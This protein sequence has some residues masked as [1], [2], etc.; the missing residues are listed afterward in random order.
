MY[1]L[2]RTNSTAGHSHK[3][4]PLSTAS[5]IIDTVTNAIPSR[6]VLRQA[7]PGV[8]AAADLL[9]GQASRDKPVNNTDAKPSP[10]PDN[11]LN[12]KG[13]SPGEGQDTANEIP[14]EQV[15]GLLHSQGI[16]D[17]QGLVSLLPLN[18]MCKYQACRAAGAFVLVLDMGGV[19]QILCN[20][21]FI[22]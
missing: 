22:V 9:L 4:E 11:Y 14:W 3:D 8:A 7:H 16:T 2:C 18:L 12:Q 10:Q 17:S 6:E 19:W 5:D 13:E 15:A 1:M 21:L 20:D